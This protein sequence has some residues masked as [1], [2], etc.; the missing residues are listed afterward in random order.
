MLKQVKVI[1]IRKTGNGWGSVL[2]LVKDIVESME[3]PL[4]SGIEVGD[5]MTLSRY[6]EIKRNGIYL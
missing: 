1:G 5:K 2:F 6:N 4:S 3:L